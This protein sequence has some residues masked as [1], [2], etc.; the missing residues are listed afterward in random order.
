MLSELLEWNDVSFG[1]GTLR[2]VRHDRAFGGCRVLYYRPAAAI[3]DMP[4]PSGAVVV[5]A[6]EDNPDGRAHMR[7]S[8][9]HERH[10]DRR[11]AEANERVRRQREVFPFK[12]HVIVG[13]SNVDTAR[14]ERLLV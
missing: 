9:G 7:I 12:E 8:R 11:A 10:I 1:N 6:R 2:G 13:G 5:R 3:D 4:Q 14:N